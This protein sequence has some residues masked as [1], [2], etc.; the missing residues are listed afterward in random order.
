MPDKYQYDSSTL[1]AILAEIT[2]EKPA[3]RS[4]VSGKDKGALKTVDIELFDLWKEFEK[5]TTILLKADI[6]S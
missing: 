3:L 2:A 5:T 1:K 6:P 4:A